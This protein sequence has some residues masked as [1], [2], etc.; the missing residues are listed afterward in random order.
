MLTSK[1]HSIPALFGFSHS[2]AETLAYQYTIPLL[3]PVLSLAV[4]YASF[5]LYVSIEHADV[6]IQ[7]FDMVGSTADEWR[8]VE[9]TKVDKACNRLN[10]PIQYSGVVIGT[11]G[12]PGGDPTELRDRLY[13]VEAMRK[14]GREDEEN[15]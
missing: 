12:E 8:L 1:Q 11:A 4:D 15:D 3:G 2:P 14:V 13:T 9:T 7:K 10:D 6:L 5:T